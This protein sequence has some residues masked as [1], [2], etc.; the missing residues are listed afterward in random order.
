MNFLLALMTLFTSTNML[1]HKYENIT[2]DDGLSNMIVRCTSQDNNGVL[3]FAT[4]SG[5]QSFDGTNFADYHIQNMEGGSSSDNRFQQVVTDKQGQLFSIN[6]SNVFKYNRLSDRF[7]AIF[8]FQGDSIYTGIINLIN[9]QEK[10][11]LF[12]STNH[13]LYISRPSGGLPYDYLPVG[14]CNGAVVYDNSIF[15]ATSNGIV[16]LE[17]YEGTYKPT[18]KHRFA[19]LGNAP[20][21]FIHADRHGNIWLQQKGNGIIY[22]DTKGKK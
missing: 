19:S 7:E 4:N 6:R 11:R 12:V 3:W 10:D 13:G 14:D 22:F 8:S 15:V 18:D 1:G 17:C 9:I 5:I 21:S 2:V 20:V 16:E